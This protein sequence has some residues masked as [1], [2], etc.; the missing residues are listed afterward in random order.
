MAKAWCGV[1]QLR[2]SGSA[3]G[4]RVGWHTRVHMTAT[5]MVSRTC[6]IRSSTAVDAALRLAFSLQLV[7]APCSCVQSVMY[8]DQSA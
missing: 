6:A 7:L 8:M 3:P 2:G 5:V 1:Q 4:A